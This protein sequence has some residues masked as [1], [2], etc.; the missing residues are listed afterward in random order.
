MSWGP[1]TDELRFQ[2]GTVEDERLREDVYK[3][4]TQAELGAIRARVSRVERGLTAEPG[5]AWKSS[6]SLPLPPECWD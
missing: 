3:S 4:G 2:N 6:Q 1:G 5:L